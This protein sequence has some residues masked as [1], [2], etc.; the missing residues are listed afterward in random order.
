MTQN[1]KLS[2]KSLKPITGG[3]RLEKNAAKAWN[4]FARYCRVKHGIKVQVTDSYRKLGR[5]GDLARNDWSQWMAWERYQQ[6]GNLAARPGTSNHGWGL[7]VDVPDQ[8]QSAIARWGAPFGWQKK[9]SDAPS[10]PWHFRWSASNANRK[11]IAYW[12]RVQP[13]DVISYGDKGPGVV[14]IKKNL[15]RHGYWPLKYTRG[16]QSYGRITRWWVRK[17]QKE[18]MNVK[19]DGVVGPKT[20]KALRS[21]PKKNQAPKPPKQEPTPKPNPLPKPKSR[22][23]A[24]I[25]N[26]NLQWDAKKYAAKYDLIVMKASE[27]KTFQDPVYIK[28]ARAARKAGLTIYS[29]HFAR[30]GNGNSG[31]A[32]A[33]NFCHQ[34]KKVGPLRKSDRYVLDW[35]DTKY[36]Q[37]GD[38]WVKQFVRE[39]SRQGVPVTIIYSG[40]WY[41]K[42]KYMPKQADGKT[43]LRYWHSAYSSKISN[44]PANAKK[45]LWAWQFTDGVNGPEPKSAPGIGRCDMNRLI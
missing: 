37:P 4:A 13:G 25:S 12:A 38:S 16:N 36:S 42:L 43:P 39:C 6:G 45:H 34:V 23:F 7:A 22:Y 14:S 8:T 18:V 10:E 40:G 41:W 30:P 11:V 28:R 15:R 44:V 27:G 3:G 1:G 24:D 9:W 29:Y 19:P 26:N 35:E 33:W 21:T 20:W 17:F 5:P 31:R 32:E 2:P